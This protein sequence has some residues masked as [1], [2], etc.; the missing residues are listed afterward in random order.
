MKSKNDDAIVIQKGKANIQFYDVHQF[1]T[2]SYWAE[3]IP[4]SAVK[5]QIDNSV[6][7]R[8]CHNKNL[9]GF[10]RVVTDFVAFA[11]LCDVYII[12]EYRGRGLSKK[13]METILNDTELKDIKNWMLSTKDAHGLY[14]KF[15]FKPLE[16]PKKI[17][18]RT[19]FEKWSERK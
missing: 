12:E 8:V 14:K 17:M 7:F 4:I 2:K 1:L 5:K 3:G 18:K 9:I 15:G 13:L 6:C 11:Y 16:E 19:L 10:A